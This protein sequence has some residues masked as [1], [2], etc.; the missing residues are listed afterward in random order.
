MLLD[1][2]GLKEI[3]IILAAESRL[4]SARIYTDE[5]T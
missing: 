4:R 1:R 5:K 2:I 3:D